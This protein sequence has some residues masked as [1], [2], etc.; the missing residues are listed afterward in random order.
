MFYFVLGCSQ[1]TNNVVIVLGEQQRDSAIYMHVSI[2]L[3][4]PLP[5]RLPHNIDQSSICYT[6]GHC[7]LS[8]LNIA[9]CRCPSLTVP[10]SHLP[11]SNQKFILKV[12]ESV[13]KVSSFLLLLFRFH[14]IRILYDISSS[15]WLSSL[16][17]IL[18]GSIHVAA[19]FFL[20]LSIHTHP[21]TSLSI[22]LSFI[23]SM[24]I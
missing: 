10:F 16:R 3:Q 8:I 11:P 14:I 6:A 12:C 17:M 2:L 20:S 18:S 15:V 1:L 19:S 4:T 22:P 9:V 5:S 21:P 24:G 13:L 23:H 7:W